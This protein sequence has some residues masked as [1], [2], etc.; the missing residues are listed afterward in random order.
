MRPVIFFYDAY[1]KYNEK[2][3]FCMAFFL[4][5]SNQSAEYFFA[6]FVNL[7]YCQLHDHYVKGVINKLKA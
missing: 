7:L 5:F 6:L 4:F 2:L 3:H 1:T